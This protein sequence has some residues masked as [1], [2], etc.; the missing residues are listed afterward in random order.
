M[1]AKDL[2][3]EEIM[4]LVQAITYLEGENQNLRGY[5]KQLQAQLNLKKSQLKVANGQIN[6]L[7]NFVYVDATL[8]EN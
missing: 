7:T 5:V 6:Q 8:D 4:A 1:N 2:S 3:E